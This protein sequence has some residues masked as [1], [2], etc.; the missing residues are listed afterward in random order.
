VTYNVITRIEAVLIN[1][2][3]GLLVTVICSPMHARAWVASVSGRCTHNIMLRAGHRGES[4][5]PRGG[6][7]SC[8]RTQS[9]R[10]SEM[11]CG[12]GIDECTCRSAGD[13]VKPGLV[14]KGSA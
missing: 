7:G 4:L 6:I 12:Y 10:V 8:Q 9:Q 13:N 5:M 2:L 1:A 14:V 3:I 11:A